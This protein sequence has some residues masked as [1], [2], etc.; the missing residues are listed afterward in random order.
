MRLVDYISRQTNQKAKITNKYDGECAIATI[1]C[2]C[3]AFA[4]MYTNTTPQKFQSQR[5]N[6][7]NHTHSTRASIAYPTNHS[8]LLSL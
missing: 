2:I 7:E 8:K 5:F 4:A 3:D 6:S 1:T